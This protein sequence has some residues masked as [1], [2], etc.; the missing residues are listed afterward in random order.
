M[1]RYDVEGVR[2]A[3]AV[4]GRLAVDDGELGA[5]DIAR[6]LD[7][8]RSTAFRLLVTLEGL[9]AVRQNRATR[10]YRLGPELIALGRSASQ[11]LDLRVE[12]RPTMAVL[13]DSTG[14]PVFLNVRGTTSAICVEHVPSRESI[15][16]YGQ[17]GL[18]LPYHACPSGYV[19]LAF[20]PDELLDRVLGA[21]LQRYASG[22]PTTAG[23]L[24]RIVAGVRER[25]I[26]FA[27]DDLD[28]R[29]SSL[30]APIFEAGNRAV[31]A[32]G[33]AGFTVDVEPRPDELTAALLDATAEI[34]ARLGGATRPPA[35]AASMFPYQNRTE[36]V[37]SS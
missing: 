5:A 2:K 4:L 7:M 24:R 22:T 13:A 23:E 17:A 27:R 35:H 25:G 10:R 30:A 31:A 20:G 6:S 19:L 15:E 33:L 8:S 34:S 14:L 18:L 36:G 37:S 26:A 16:L 29:V 9:G 28:E 32:L 11:Q 3:F 1:P 21:P 12:A